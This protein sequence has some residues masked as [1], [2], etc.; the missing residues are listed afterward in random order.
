MKP[1]ATVPN[2]VIDGDY[3]R[4]GA[5]CVRNAFNPQFVTLATE[6]VETRQVVRFTP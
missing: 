2:W 4:D 3:W 5:V 1:S 6:A